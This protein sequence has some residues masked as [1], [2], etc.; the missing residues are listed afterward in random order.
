MSVN[1][2]K[3]ILKFIFL[4]YGL[5][6]PSGCGK[7]NILRAIVGRVTLDSGVL[8]VFGKETGKRGHEIPGSLVGYMPE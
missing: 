8:D 1:F 4:S 5:L 3:M 6:G 7:K 2:S